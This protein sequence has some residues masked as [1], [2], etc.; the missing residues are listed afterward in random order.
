MLMCGWRIEVWRKKSCILA[1]SKLSSL[2]GEVSVMLCVAI[3]DQGM[4]KVTIITSDR[5][6]GK[7]KLMD[8]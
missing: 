5:D 2:G 7:Q 4:A 6:K 8:G 1:K 3:K